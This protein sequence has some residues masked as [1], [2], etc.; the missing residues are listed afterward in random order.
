MRDQPGIIEGLGVP[1]RQIRAS[2]GGSKKPS[3]E[4]RSRRMS[5]GRKVVTIN[6]EE[7]PAYGVAFAGRCGSGGNWQRGRSLQGHHP[8]SKRETG[9]NRAAQGHPRSRVHPSQPATFTGP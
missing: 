3:V 1:V 5:L 4:G 9:V 2:G 7:G 6:T 8:R